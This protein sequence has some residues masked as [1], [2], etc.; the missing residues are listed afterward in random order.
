MPHLFDRLP[1]VEGNVVLAGHRDTF[2]R[3][4]KDIRQGD[5]ITVAT[6][7]REFEYVVESTA[8]VEPTDIAA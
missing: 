3:P 4:L 8:I 6:S 7:Q 1:G 5:R 2:F